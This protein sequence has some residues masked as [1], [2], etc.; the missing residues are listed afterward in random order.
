M[1][2]LSPTSPDEH[3]PQLL[4]RAV[5]LLVGFAVVLRPFTAGNPPYE[6]T[7]VIL[8]CLL[9]LAFSLWGAAACLRG[10]FVL[11]ASA[12]WLPLFA[13]FALV[14]LAVNHA[15]AQGNGRLAIDEGYVWVGD[16]LLFFLVANHFR[17]PQYF[18]FLLCLI[19]ASL[20]FVSLY[21][22]Y[23]RFYGIAYFIHILEQTPE[24]IVANVGNNPVYQKL[25]RSRAMTLRSTGT[26][27]Y[28]NA[29]GGFCL[30]LVPIILGLLTN[31]RKGLPRTTIII[32]KALAIGGLTAGVLSGSRAGFLAAK[33]CEGIILCSFL[34][35]PRRS[36]AAM[37]GILCGISF[38]TAGGLAG[39]VI[40]TLL[41]KTFLTTGAAS[42]GGMLVFAGIWAVEYCWLTQRLRGDT[43]LPAGLRWGG[44]LTLLLG[45]LLTGYLLSAPAWKTQPAKMNP[46]QAKLLSLRNDVAKMVGVRANYWRSA[47]G[48][49]RDHPWRGVGLGNFGTRYPAYKQPQGWAVKRVHNQYLQ[50]AADGG[51]PLLIAFL[52]IWVFFFR[53]LWRDSGATEESTT[54][55]EAPAPTNKKSKSKL[56]PTTL[57]PPGDLYRWGRFFGG[58]M[59]LVVYILYGLF[60]GLSSEYFRVELFGG[61]ADGS[62]RAAT[63]SWLPLLIHGGVHFLILPA[64]WLLV[65][66]AAWYALE[67]L[68]PQRLA[69]WLSYG[70]AGMLLHIFADMY[71]SAAGI[72]M[73]FWLVAGLVLSTRRATWHWHLPLAR[74]G[75]FALLW[76]LLTLAPLFLYIHPYMQGAL[77]VYAFENRDAAYRRARDSETRHKE[78]TEAQKALGAALKFR[79]H[80]ATLYTKQAEYLFAALSLN[81][82]RQLPSNLSPWRR[83]RLQ[84]SLMRS[85]DIKIKRRILAATDAAAQYNPQSSG[86]YARRAAMR[87]NLFPGDRTAAVLAGADYQAASKRNPYRPGYRLAEARLEF[88]LH[89]NS[90]A[91]EELTKAL[92][93][94]AVITD[95]RARLSAAEE[96]EARALLRQLRN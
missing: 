51:I 50:F 28:P 93:I 12:V 35:P 65:Y 94:Q 91:R 38:W 80:D 36:L 1:T 40:V 62:I 68:P 9:G 52:A 48:M 39:G 59:F 49:I 74:R 15:L 72:S 57:T 84:T 64:S 30:L 63:G 2:S 31:L 53:S 82:S 44:F 17:Q 33:V 10:E 60:G 43:P 87:L 83:L 42:G 71:F 6:P 75:G 21:A 67:E 19:L 4:E 85:V 77:A 79:P 70:L 23:Q 41:L 32:L 13:C 27:G 88:S 47:V 45:V 16:G 76:L 69:R 78:F 24:S 89:Q 66:R 3:L 61:V 96:K 34:A 56:P 92:Q 26:F 54:T 29:L 37:F 5:V 25:L 7:T 90:A 81:L 46:L 8:L 58:L 86:V 18:R 55:P 73:F 11:T 22:I 14:A 20:A 95:E